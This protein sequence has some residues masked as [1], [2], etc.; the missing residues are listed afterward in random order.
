MYM[1]YTLVSGTQLDWNIR[2]L[3]YLAMIKLM[4]IKISFDMGK[5]V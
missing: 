1:F 2:L 5:T 4:V 3:L